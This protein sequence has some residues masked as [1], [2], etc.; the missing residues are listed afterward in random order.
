MTPR[1]L[2]DVHAH[3]LPPSYLDAVRRAGVT[4]FDGGYRIPQWTAEDAVAFMDR[5]GIAVQLLSVSSPPVALLAGTDGAAR[6][7][8]H[9]NDDIAEAVARHPRRFRGIAVLPL[10]DV[11]ATLAAIDDTMRDP[12]FVGVMVFTNYAGTYLGDPAFD[13][14][15]AALNR[16]GA[17]VLL[18]PTSPVCAERTSLS[19]PAPIIEFPF[20]TTRAVTNLVY[21]GTLRRFP[22]VRVVVPHAGAAIPALAARIGRFADGSRP[23]DVLAQL[24]RLYFDVAMSV[25]QHALATLL[26]LANRDRILFGT[27]FPFSPDAGENVHALTTCGA[28]T[29]DERSGTGHRNALLLFPELSSLLDSTAVNPGTAR[30]RESRPAGRRSARS[31]G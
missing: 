14:V 1:A 11:P 5:Y 2:V 23:D 22:D 17:V 27:D 20:D 10:P 29:D 16:H 31:P 30:T 19:R 3:C 12:H 13:P 7:A 18:H 4:S 28:L 6:L 26:T 9:V 25:N 21:T 24:R 15:F 8:R